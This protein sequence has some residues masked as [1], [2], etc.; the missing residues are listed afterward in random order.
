[1]NL[2]NIEKDKKVDFIGIG[3][4]IYKHDKKYFNFKKNNWNNN[5][6]N[7]VVKVNSKSTISSIGEMRK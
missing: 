1:M 2:I 6:K 4:Y 5:L 3:N 7:I